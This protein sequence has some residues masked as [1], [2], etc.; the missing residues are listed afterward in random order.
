MDLIEEN[1]IRANNFWAV[2][3]IKKQLKQKILE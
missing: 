2:E 1:K 3:Q